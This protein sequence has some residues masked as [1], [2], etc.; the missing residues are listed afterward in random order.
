MGRGKGRHV[1]GYR[2]CGD[3]GV[4]GGEDGVIA[5]RV[6][7]RRTGMRR[8][9]TE[10]ETQS[11]EDEIEGERAAESAS[12]QGDGVSRDCPCKLQLFLRPH[13]RYQQC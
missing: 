1:G 6:G 2:N 13:M 7:A 12:N 9:M 4:R 11:G 8:R 10:Q 3:A 5:G